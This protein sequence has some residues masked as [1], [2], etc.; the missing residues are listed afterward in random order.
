MDEQPT[1]FHNIRLRFHLGPTNL[2][3]MGCLEETMGLYPVIIHQHDFRFD[4]YGSPMDVADAITGKLLVNNPSP[5]SPP[6]QVISPWAGL[7]IQTL[8]PSVHETNGLSTRIDENNRELSRTDS[9]LSHNQYTFTKNPQT[10]LSGDILEYRRS[11][12]SSSPPT[13]SSPSSPITGDQDVNDSTPS[14]PP[15]IYLARPSICD[16]IGPPAHNGTK[17]SKHGDK[18]KRDQKDEDY[19]QS[20]FRA[21]KTDYQMEQE[22]RA[23]MGM[24]KF[25]N[26]P[27]PWT[28]SI[29]LSMHEKIALYILHISGGLMSY[30]VEEKDL[31]SCA[32][33]DMTPTDLETVS[34]SAG[35]SV[36][37]SKNQ[38]TRSD[39]IPVW[40]QVGDMKAL[41][42]ILK[43]IAKA[44]ATE[45]LY[46]LESKWIS[47]EERIRRSSWELKLRQYKGPTA[48][49]SIEDEW[50][51]F[52]DEN[53]QSYKEN[54]IWPPQQHGQPIIVTQESALYDQNVDMVM[55][56]DEEVE[57]EESDDHD[58]WSSRI[59]SPQTPSTL[60][61]MHHD[62]WAGP[63]PNR[64][65]ESRGSERLQTRHRMS[66][67]GVFTRATSGSVMSFFDDDEPQTQQNQQGEEAGDGTR[68]TSS[69]IP[70]SR[71]GSGP[72]PRKERY[73]GTAGTTMSDPGLIE[74]NV[75]FSGER[76]SR[77]FGS[78]EQVS[79]IIL[80]SNSR[81]TSRTSTPSGRRV[82]VADGSGRR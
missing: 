5:T 16:I 80:N 3:I 10:I 28:L 77:H 18:D 35:L 30:L 11:Y 81:T 14:I 40:I 6:Q 53:N 74:R 41:R 70:P 78:P 47:D 22:R 9:D 33:K 32:H 17:L 2:G 25:G 56:E 63:P 51:T 21:A 4:V 52:K 20:L 54:S 31:I 44:L 75:S 46:S 50:V 38:L 68:D 8:H 49:N 72:L 79:R 66:N 43:G 59:S 24:H 37:I 67:N 76:M 58:G 55:A 69:S 61:V 42:A 13:S 39:E 60:N 73:R 57:E 71:S 62:P 1:A 15:L 27:T 48:H 34:R 19:G 82:V 12:S 29:I 7:G 26:D 65:R 36:G 64:P 45:P 23:D